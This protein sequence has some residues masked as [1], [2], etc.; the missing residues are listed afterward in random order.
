MACL[1]GSTDNRLYLVD[2]RAAAT[3]TAIVHRSAHPPPPRPVG[4]NGLRAASLA[5]EKQ[6][7][8]F[9]TITT[10]L[11]QCPPKPVL[12]PLSSLLSM[13]AQHGALTV[14][15]A[16]STSSDVGRANSIE[17]SFLEKGLT[18]IQNP[19]NL[20]IVAS[21]GIVGAGVAYF[22]YNKWLE[23][24]LARPDR[25]TFFGRR[26]IK[27]M[28][29][30]NTTH[31]QHSIKNLHSLLKSP[32]QPPASVVEVRIPFPPKRGWLE[33]QRRLFADWLWHWEGAQTAR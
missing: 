28:C 13:A 21:A 23:D 11:T 18:W 30:R 9:K 22:A 5:R 31:M 32:L 29:G 15:S 10:T 6:T 33:K 16:K 12:R 7:P 26:A 8:T 3:L 20:S 4:D 17:E 19:R 25:S 1:L 14:T 24:Q 27:H 2:M